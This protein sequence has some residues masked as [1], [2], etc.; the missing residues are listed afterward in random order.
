MTKA[1]VDTRH[2]GNINLI[3]TFAEDTIGVLV[4]AGFK[5]RYFD[6]PVPTPLVGTGS[7]GS[8]NI[9]SGLE[10]SMERHPFVTRRGLFAAPLDSTAAPGQGPASAPGG[11]RGGRDAL[12]CPLPPGQ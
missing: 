1:E 9:G 11:R 6:H 5:V 4:A 2:T 12:G 7:P 3:R 8:S 10:V